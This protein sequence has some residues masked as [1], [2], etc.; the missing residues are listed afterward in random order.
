MTLINQMLAKAMTARDNAYAPYSNFFVGCCLQSETGEL[1]VGANVEN[2]S[3]PSGQCAEASA[4]GN[5]ISHG[6]K[7]IAAIVVVGTGDVACFPCGN[8]RQKLN[9][10]ILPETTIHV[11]KSDRIA[12]SMPFSELL[13]HSFE[14]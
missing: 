11:A 6:L 13:P 8:C 2:A 9:E 4:I 1:F 5:L 10:F 12:F 7:K 3:Y 14:F